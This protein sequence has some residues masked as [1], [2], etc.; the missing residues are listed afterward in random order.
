MNDKPQ[1]PTSDESLMAAISH[2]FGIL[3]A[4]IVWATQK[5]KSRFVR[6]QSIQAMAFDLLISAFVFLVVGGLLVLIFGLI[7]LG[8][9][10]IAILGSQNNPTAEPVRAFIALMTAIP[11][12]IT[13]ILI[14]ISAIIFIARLIAAIETFQ[15]KD[16]HYPWLGNLLERSVN[17]K[18]QT[19]G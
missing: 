14:P 9:G 2:F 1:T 16:F 19:D 4:L 7:A 15:G 13:C 18:A 11:F 5:E 8:I 10:D 17:S 3:V 12:L 6:F